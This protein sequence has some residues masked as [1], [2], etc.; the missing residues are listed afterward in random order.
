MPVPLKR[1]FAVA[2]ETTLLVASLFVP[3]LAS[4][5]VRTDQADYAPGS[6]VT[7]SGDDSD[8]AGYLP[9]ETIDV[10]VSGPNGYAASCSATADDQGAWSCQVTLWDT[11]MA[12]GAYSYTATGQESG[13]SE[14]GAFTD[15]INSVTT[16]TSSVNPS[17]VGQAV[18]FSATVRS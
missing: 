16:V 2:L 13:Y 5:A 8:G 14:T 9:G 10:V 6:V 3:A 15:A 11:A 17:S 12:V 7:I 18:T 4:A 1:R